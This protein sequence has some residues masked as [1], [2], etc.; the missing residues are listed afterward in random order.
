MKQISYQYNI[1]TACVEIKYDNGLMVSIDCIAAEN[2]I[3]RNRFEQAEL[4]YPIYND[5]AGYAE[6]IL[7]GDPKAYLKAVTEYKP[8]DEIS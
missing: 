7:T 1:D 5:P 8:L 4:D 3:A 6:L 2:Q